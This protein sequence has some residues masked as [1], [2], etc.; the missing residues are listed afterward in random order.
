MPKIHKTAD[1]SGLTAKQARTIAALLAQPNFEQ[2]A[3][4][5]GVAPRTIYTW[6]ELPVFRAELRLAQA[7]VIEQAQRRLLAG[8]QKALDAL[9]YL[10][11]DAESEN[12]RRQ[13]ANDWLAMLFRYREAG[14]I[15]ERISELEQAVFHGDK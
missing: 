14:D 15:E 5:A 7:G 13:A 9:E 8:Q 2:A 1:N 10:M 3:A 4:A 12:V 6:L 11:A